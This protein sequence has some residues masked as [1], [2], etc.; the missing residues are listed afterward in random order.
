M[1]K[2]GAEAI[3]LATGMVVGYPPCRSISYFK[4]FIEEKYKVKVIVGTHPIPQKYYDTHQNLATWSGDM[5]QELIKPILGD[6]KLRIE[7]N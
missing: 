7:Y 5:W 6:E 1:I 4:N 2:N 3:H